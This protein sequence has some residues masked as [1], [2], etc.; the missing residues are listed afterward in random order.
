M[1]ELEP[2]RGLRYDTG[3][4]RVADV[5]APPYDVVGSNERTRL[6]SR[7]PHNSIRVELP[8]PDLGRGLDRY[9]VASALIDRWRSNGLLS[10]EK[11]PA[12]YPYRMTTRDDRTTTGV[13]G[14]LVLGGEGSDDILPHEQTMP[15]PR[16]DRLDLLRATGVNTSPIWGLSLA[17]GLSATFEVLGDP[18]ADAVDDDGVRHQLWV[19]D[20]PVAIEAVRRVFAEAPVVIADG[21]HRYETALAYQR[22]RHTGA[23]DAPGPYDAVMALI[24][25]LSDDQLHVDPIHRTVSGLPAGFDAAAAFGAWFDVVRAG[26]TSERTLG[27]LSDAQSMALV[28]ADNAYLLFPK[29]EGYDAA[30]S[31]LDSSLVELVLADVGHHEVSYRNSRDEALGAVTAGDADLAV[32]LRPVT[33]EQIAEWAAARRR[34]PPKTSYFSPKPRTGMVFRAIDL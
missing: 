18:V 10:T 33:V 31:E 16:S 20:D 12:L 5:I 34:M 28:T 3:A 1:P 29:P 23:G 17:A 19:M 27:A 30:G 4:V 22:E 11:S 8:E 26:P 24:V 6:A 25:E 21:H 13:I 14:A 7:S 9:T 2:F 15:K 32:L